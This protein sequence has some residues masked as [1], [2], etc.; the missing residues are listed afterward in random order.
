[1]INGDKLISRDKLSLIM[2]VYQLTITI[3][4]T[5]LFY[6]NKQNENSTIKN[7]LRMCTNFNNFHHNLIHDLSKHVASVLNFFQNY[8]LSITW[9]ASQ[10]L[11]HI[12]LSANFSRDKFP[13]KLLFSRLTSWISEK[14]NIIFGICALLFN[15]ANKRKLYFCMLQ[16]EQIVKDHVCPGLRVERRKI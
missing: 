9:Q 2:T 1:M 3:L 4:N 14:K 6:L 7:Y 5:F 15:T 12:K 8:V 10:E 16:Q 11:Q 13:I